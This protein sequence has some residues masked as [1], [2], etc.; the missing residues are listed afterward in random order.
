MADR[1]RLDFWSQSGASLR[2]KRWEK[3]ETEKQKKE[4]DKQHTT[5]GRT[6]SGENEHADDSREIQLASLENTYGNLRFSLKG[7]EE[8]QIEAARSAGFQEPVFGTARKRL[9]PGHTYKRT[10]QGG[11]NYADS[12]FKEES[13]VR[14]VRNLKTAS[15]EKLMS[16]L[17]GL[18]EKWE[19]KTLQEM[20]KYGEDEG[21]LKKIYQNISYVKDEAQNLENKEEKR[22]DGLGPAAAGSRAEAVSEEIEEEDGEDFSEDNFNKK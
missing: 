6:E 17:E 3:P 4:Q 5:E 8:I 9:E 15:S 12:H 22:T 14:I 2:E 11:K 19:Q 16:Q 7:K 10:G 20:M 13:A 21:L 1:G 18:C